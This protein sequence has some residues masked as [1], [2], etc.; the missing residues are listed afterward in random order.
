M[1]TCSLGRDVAG[2][3]RHRRWVYAYAFIMVAPGR[4]KAQTWRGTAAMS[5]TARRLEEVVGTLE[6]SRRAPWA[7][8][9]SS[10]AHWNCASRASAMWW[11]RN[12]GAAAIAHARATR[13]RA[14]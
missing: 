5:S 11:T 6:Q 14:M 10:F 13:F 1:R 8:L 3:P 7:P 9:R 4:A 2:A 12:E